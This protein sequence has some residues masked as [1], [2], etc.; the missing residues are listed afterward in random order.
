MNK[1]LIIRPTSNYDQQQRQRRSVPV[2]YA[3]WRSH[4]PGPRHLRVAVPV[5]IKRLTNHVMVNHRCVR[6]CVSLQLSQI[7]GH[8]DQLYTKLP[9]GLRVWQYTNAIAVTGLAAAVSHHHV[10]RKREIL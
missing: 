9:R 7:L 8:S 4:F 10:M 3:T 5:F 6:V 2:S 1:F